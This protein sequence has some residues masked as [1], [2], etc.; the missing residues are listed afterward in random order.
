MRAPSVVVL[1]P[2]SA[3]SH[4]WRSA[5]TPP[6]AAS[7]EVHS[8]RVNTIVVIGLRTSAVHERTTIRQ[9]LYPGVIIT[10]PA[11]NSKASGSKGPLFKKGPRSL[12]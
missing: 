11:G 12:S 2:V 10:P 5:D 8:K 3:F 4:N 7:A 1:V 9:L 6:G